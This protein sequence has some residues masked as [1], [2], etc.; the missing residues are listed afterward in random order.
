MFFLTCFI[1]NLM[2]IYLAVFEK[3]KNIYNYTTIRPIAMGHQSNW[4]DKK[5]EVDLPKE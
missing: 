5:E 3:V 1:P 4:W 2:K